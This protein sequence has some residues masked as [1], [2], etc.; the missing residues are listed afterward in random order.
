V[1]VVLLSGGGGGAKL[2][3][4][5]A[6]VL[7]PGELTVVGNVG[8]DLE[9]L[10]LA[11]SPDLDSLLY[12][13]SGLLDDERGWG[14]ADESWRALG[15][16]REWGGEDWF[17]LGD[18]DLGLHLVRTAA[19]QEGA[20]LSEVTARLVERARIAV[21][22]LPATD[23]RL[24]TRVHTPAGSF[25]FQEWF[26]GRRQEDEVEGVEY[27]GAEGAAPAPGVLEALDAADAVVIAPSNPYLSIGPILA[28]PEI[29][30]ALARR[31]VRCVAVSPLVGGQA[32]T[33]PLALMLSRMAGGTSPAHV[34]DRYKG[35][36]DL[37][38]VDHADMPAQAGVP[39]LA[40]DTLM[41]DPDA[42]S[43]LA[44]FVVEA[45]CT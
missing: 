24:R 16:V 27:D 9:I 28:V 39:L 11:V 26:V 29:R 18:L 13:L 2:A 12:A 8:D 42:E 23:D 25:P 19:L 37:L 3:R 34:T 10:G 44:A 41:R 14:R 1:K 7:E 22:L 36:L 31:R 4:G 5:L 17:R 15:A 35:L 21:R 38:V 45:A 43:R 30:E 32:V 6:N 33:G 20:R 40:T